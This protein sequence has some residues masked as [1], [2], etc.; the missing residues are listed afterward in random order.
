[1]SPSA[2]AITEIG[3]IKLR[4]GECL[5]TFQTMVNPDEPIPAAITYLTGITEAMVGPA[6]CIAAVLPSFL[7]F[8]GRGTVIV[9][10][11]IR[12]DLSFLAAA[13]DA[14]GYPPLDHVAVDTSAIARRLVRD[15]VDNCK[16]STLA[17]RFRLAS[18]PTHRALADAK[19][20]GD[21]LHCLL[22]RTGTLGVTALD[23][24]LVLPDVPRGPQ[25]Q[26]LRLATALP[27]RPGRFLFRNR[28]RTTLLAG[29]ADDVH[30]E[31][32]SFFLGARK[33]RVTQLVKQTTAI[34]YVA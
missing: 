12:F 18:T 16:L 10:H 17:Y 23:D 31:A 33:K 7:E 25:L 19:A 28:A 29:R 26:K 2:A 9:G 6:P 20:T 1:M 15:E 11:N 32:R 27:R 4:G 13:L 3:A 22:E 5:G 8:L 30:C 21:L 34:E 14:E 24:L